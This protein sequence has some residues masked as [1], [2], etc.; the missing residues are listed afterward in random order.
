[1]PAANA[2]SDEVRRRLL[3]LPNV[4]D[5][6][7]HIEAE[8]GPESAT[9]TYEAVKLCAAEVGV[10]IHEFWVQSVDDDRSLHLHVGVAPQLTLAEAHALVDDLE[11]RIMERLPRVNAV[12]THIELATVDVLPSAGVSSHLQKRVEQGIMEA[13][14]PILGIY[15]PHDIVVRQVEGQLF[16]NLEAFVDG[17]LYIADAHERSTEFEQAIRDNVANVGEIII[18]LEP[19]EEQLMT[20]DD[21]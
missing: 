18:H 1:M 16:V 4:D 7:V 8:R 17:N 20:D 19:Q 5:V 10:T 13:I 6:T 12:H 2:I 3:A 11:R 14:R 21:I 15:E 9:N